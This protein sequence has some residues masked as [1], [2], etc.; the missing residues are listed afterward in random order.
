MTTIPCFLRVTTSKLSQVLAWGVIALL[1][2][3]YFHIA[4]VLDHEFVSLVTV[5]L[6]VGQISSRARIINLEHNV[7][8]F[9]GQIS[10]GIYVIHPL[11][12]FA[13]AN[14]M[15]DIQMNLVVKYMVVYSSIVAVTVLVSYLSYAYFE[16][17]FLQRKQQYSV[18]KTSASKEYLQSKDTEQGKAIVT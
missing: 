12:I 3:N 17:W 10:Y 6:I 18:I 5:I 7:F 4:S 8:D 15:K 14:V 2:L 11:I 1:A 9:L 13:A 16:K